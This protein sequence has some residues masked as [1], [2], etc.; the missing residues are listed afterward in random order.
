MDYIAKKTGL[1]RYTV[2]MALNGNLRVR[3]ETRQLVLA[4][5]EKY[6][7]IPNRNAVGLVKGKTNLI[8]V[9]VPYLTDDFYREFIEFL[10]RTARKF[11][12]QL[13]YRSSYN[14]NV[15][16]TEIIKNFLSLKVCAMIIVP[17]VVNPDQRIHELAKKNIP[18]VY[19]DR[20]WSE[21]RYHVIND[22]YSG[23]RQMTEALITAGRTPAYVGSFYRDSNITAKEREQ[24]YCD[25]MLHHKLPP[26]LI[27]CSYSQE[28]QDN[29]QFGYDN[30]HQLIADNAI[31]DALVCVTDAVALGAMRAL[32][33]AGVI[34]GKD[35][36][37][38]GHD[39]LRFS[40]FLSPSLTTVRQRKDL[41]ALTCIEIIDACLHNKPPAQKKYM[42]EPEII[43]RESA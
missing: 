39:N 43:R 25:A 35:V 23:V 16:E 7:Y 13:A 18:V 10:D 3:E 34:P 20:Q 26:R 6:G 28:R 36:L 27:D 17:V 4:A 8:G 37:V 5:C 41:F 15:V 29:E 12:Y 1:S 32:N 31:P 21:D 33:N 14:D 2:S 42:F 38:A 40:A 9:V 11:D 22:N 30:I 19:F 24:G